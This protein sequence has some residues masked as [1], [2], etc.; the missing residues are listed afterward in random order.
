[1]RPLEEAYRKN[2]F[3]GVM[4]ARLAGLKETAKTE[5]VAQLTLAGFAARANRKEEALRYLERAY[6][7]REPL[8]VRLLH[9]PALDSLHSEPRFKTLVKKMGLPGGEQSGG[10]EGVAPH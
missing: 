7:Q 2:G 4:D 5:Y 1:M 8:M 10:S 9:E 6:E 3:V